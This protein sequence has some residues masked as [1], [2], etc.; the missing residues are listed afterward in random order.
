MPNDVYLNLGIIKINSKN[1]LI[2]QFRRGVDS[3]TS[4]W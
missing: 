1:D 4:H 2:G 3:L